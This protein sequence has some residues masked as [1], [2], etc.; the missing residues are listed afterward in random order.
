MGRWIDNSQAESN[1]PERYLTLE[2][3]ETNPKVSACIHSAVN[4]CFTE[5]LQLRFHFEKNSSL[6]GDLIYFSFKRLRRRATP[7]RPSAALSKKYA[8]ITLPSRRSST[9]IR[10]ENELRRKHGLS[11]NS[12]PSSISRFSIS[13]INNTPGLPGALW[14]VQAHF[15]LY[16]GSAFAFFVFIKP[17]IYKVVLST[18]ISAGI[19]ND[20]PLKEEPLRGTDTWHT[21]ANNS[22]HRSAISNLFRAVFDD[23]VV[24]HFHWGICVHKSLTKLRWRVPCDESW[25]TMIYGYR[26]DVRNEYLIETNVS[27]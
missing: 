15:K 6:R 3:P 25:E 12:W 9:F 17:W 18:L 19:S 5:E 2:H 14:L 16:A 20:A 23:N 22:A 1:S 13:L 27:S 21:F 11:V 4:P 8:S 24:E 26:C 7:A 10:P